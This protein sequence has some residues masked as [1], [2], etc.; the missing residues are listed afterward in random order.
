MRQGEKGFIAFLLLSVMGSVMAGHRV[1]KR[2]VVMERKPQWK[3]SKRCLNGGLSTMGSWDSYWLWCNI[4]KY[5]PCMK[6]VLLSNK[7][8]APSIYML[9]YFLIQPICLF[10]IPAAY[11]KCSLVCKV[12]HGHVCGT[13]GELQLWGSMSWDHLLYIILIFSLHILLSISISVTHINFSL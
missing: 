9:G 7:K 8:D 5:V 4:C 1:H 12:C 13:L 6:T 3:L 11:V 10:F 2:P